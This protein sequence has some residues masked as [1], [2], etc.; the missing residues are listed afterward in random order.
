MG[1]EISTFAYFFDYT[2]FLA[3]K[4]HRKAWRCPELYRAAN[5]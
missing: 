2:P 4:A 1:A 5:Y 3:L